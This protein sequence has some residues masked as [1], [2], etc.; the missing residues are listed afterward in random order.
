MFM[1]NKQTVYCILNCLLYE[2]ILQ[3]GNLDMKCRLEKEYNKHFFSRKIKIDKEST[4]FI[5][6]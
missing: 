6:L 1:N 4:S 5:I 2:H 3:Q